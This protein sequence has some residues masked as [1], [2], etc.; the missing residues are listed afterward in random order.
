MVLDS[1]QTMLF[2]PSWKDVGHL[3]DSNITDRDIE[4]ETMLFASDLDFAYNVGGPITQEFIT[5]F[6]DPDTNYIIDSRVHMLMEG[7]YPCIPGWHNDDV[8]RSGPYNQPY[9]EQPTYDPTHTLMIINDCSSTEFICPNQTFELSDPVNNPRV[10]QAWSREID[11]MNLK[12]Q[13]LKSGQ[14]IEF[15]EHDFHRG[16]AA[17]RNGWR[18]FIRATKDSNRKIENK[19]RRQANIYIPT[20]DMGW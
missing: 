17:T 20:V 2:T 9:Q 19:I 13:T 1:K 4:N 15:G 12:T 10:Y 14:V 3:D 6:L 11:N 18:L 16:T 7:W 8:S 5:R